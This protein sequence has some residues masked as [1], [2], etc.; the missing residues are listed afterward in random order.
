[1][2]RRTQSKKSLSLIFGSQL[3][4]A[5]YSIPMG[6]FVSALFMMP[7]AQAA[8]CKIPKSYYKNV[9][10]TASSGYFLAV[11]DF[12]A[13]VALLNSKG[14]K[15][16][17]LSRYQKVDADKIAGGLLPVL[18]N[19]HVG[20]L[21]MQGREVIPATYDMLKESQGWARPVSDGR[22]V[23]KRDGNYGVIDT[24][25]KTIVS[26]SASISDIDDYRGGV[27]QVRKN[28][29]ISWVDKNGK[30]TSNP[31]GSDSNN[32]EPSS[33]KQTANSRSATASAQSRQS[34]P[35]RFTT[36][37]P[38]QQDG[39]W[40]F[41]DE[42]NVTMIT[43]SFDDARPFSE[44]L[45]GVRIDDNWGFINLGGELVIPFRFD[46]MGVSSGDSY[47]GKPAFTFANGKAWIGNLKN[48]NK[49]CIDKE[50]VS[51]GCD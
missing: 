49:M 42:N 50:G 2:H 5:R 44:G 28:Q 17:D 20:Y 3:K 10:C 12:G 32:N 43:Y 23:V 47:Q 18:R 29:A 27:T 7:T 1:M 15:V 37:Q 21:N 36:L 40:G 11:K 35:N 48:G 34:A 6:L 22:I 13:P 26:F 45:A 33:A 19:S 31:N 30:V 51:V 4:M 38:R 16:V 24:A 9:S 8:S 46:K 25:N 14:K 39:R 41:V